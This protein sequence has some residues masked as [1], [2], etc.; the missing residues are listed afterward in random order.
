MKAAFLIRCSTKNQDLSR[1]T[2]DLT[3]LAESLGYDYDLENLVYGEKITGKDDVTKKNRDSIDRLLKAAKEQ[4]FDL[5]LVSEVSR[6]SRDP[7]SGRVYVRLLI[8]MGIPV[9]FKD[10]DT[11][12]IDPETGKKVRDAELVIGGAFDAAWKYLKSMKTQI[13]SARRNQLDNGAISVGKPYFGYKWRGGKDKTEKTQWVIDEDAKEV[14]IDTFNEYLK[15]GATLKSTAL[16]ITAKY[17]EKFGRKFSLGTIEHILTFDSYHTG[18]K[19]INLTDPDREEVEVFKV[20]VPKIISTE[21]FEAAAKKRKGNRVKEEPLPS[22]TTYLLSKL[23][24]CPC[25]GY[26]MTPRA[27]GS[28]KT[29]DGRGANGCY[30]YING[31]KA[32]SWMCMSG[33]NN[34]TSCKNRTSIANEKLEPIIWELVK[35]ELIAFANLNDEDRLKKLEEIEGKI[36]YLNYNIQNYQKEIDKLSKKKSNAFQ[37]ALQA[38]EMAGDDA[39][40]KAM[41]MEE[42]GKVAKSLRKEE[43]TFTNSIEQAKG[44]IETLALQKI[45]YSQP[46]LP[47]DVIEKAEANPIEQRNLIKELITKI[48]P[49]RITTFKKK[50]REKGKEIHKPYTATDIVTLKY[51]VVLVEVV[52]INGTYYVF[53]NA[54]GKDAIRY[55]Y[56]LSADVV[57]TGSAD[58]TEYVKSLGDELFYISSPYLYYSD[59]RAEELD[60]VIDINEFV[61][62]AKANNQVITYQYIPDED[63]LNK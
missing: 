6:M 12:T 41:A 52:T 13:A 21:I 25:C 16:A 9:Y 30:R 43:I 44:E 61:E 17:G 47:K 35:K 34:L 62:I 11:W 8:N 32:L 26:T 45:Y 39:D 46:T 4:K 1:Q 38:S 7:A 48:V 2:R 63:N 36:E 22:Q 27:K 55:A 40:M 53:Y 37:F 42:Y 57:Y 31:K 58:A 3:R 24:K 10:I 5:V 23:I 19:E 56:Y 29:A 50:R 60:R 18:I 20:D 33:V 15:D 28:D 49:Y 14:V 59:E 54:N 51:G